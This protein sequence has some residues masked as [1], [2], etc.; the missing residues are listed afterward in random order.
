MG[1]VLN[2]AYR[3]SLAGHVAGMA[4]VMLPVAAMSVGCAV[5]VALFMPDRKA[6]AEVVAETKKVQV[7]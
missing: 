7:A 6:S 1:T 2:N 3:G 5:V 4:E